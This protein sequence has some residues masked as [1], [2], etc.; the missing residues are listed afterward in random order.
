MVSSS[1]SSVENCRS[2][3]SYSDT[4]SVV[5]QPIPSHRY[6]STGNSSA[7][8]SVSSASSR[9]R[10]TTPT[11]SLTC[12]ELYQKYSPTNYTPKI[13]CNRE[14]TPVNGYRHPSLSSISSSNSISSI[15]NAGVAEL[16]GGDER[17]SL[18][19]RWSRQ[20]R[21]PILSSY[22]ET[23]CVRP[24]N[25]VTKGVSDERCDINKP[26]DTNANNNGEFDVN[27]VSCNELNIDDNQKTTSLS[28]DTV[29]VTNLTNNR[30][31]RAWRDN[32]S[33]ELV[34]NNN[35]ECCKRVND[36]DS[37]RRALRTSTEGDGVSD[38]FNHCCGSGNGFR[39]TGRPGNHED[40]SKPGTS[41][42]NQIF[43]WS[44]AGGESGTSGG[45]HTGPVGVHQATYRGRN[46][47]I[48]SNFW[49]GGIIW[50]WDLDII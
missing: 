33:Y 2:V 3:S 36:L 8:S 15:S 12:D 32:G 29:T 1:Q 40:S 27:N 5:S 11:S 30:S 48:V 22:D 25:E 28:S 20:V 10:T 42:R 47:S 46:D 18:T 39:V 38:E 37:G 21:R 6:S 7:S 35:Q 19:D 23:D 13:S 24:H 31:D 4:S 17:D 14:T 45:G 41:R 26:S 49:G 16:H 50:D 44:D 43:G 34:T 9:D